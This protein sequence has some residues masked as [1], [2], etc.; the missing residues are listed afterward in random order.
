MTR[1]WIREC[2][3]LIGSSS[4]AI[5]VSQLRIRFEVRMWDVQHPGQ[6]DVIVTNLSKETSQKIQKEYDKVLLQVGWRDGQ[7]ATLFEGETV[8]KRRGRETPT[9]VYDALLVREAQTAYSFATISKTLASGH[10][11][12]DQIDACLEAL[13]PYGI[14]AGYIPDLP[15]TKMPRGRV[16]FGM[17]RQQLRT[18]CASTGTSWHIEGNKLVVLENGKPRPGE[19]IV[20]NSR[21]GLIG[22]P[23]QTFGGIEARCLLNPDIKWGSLVKIDQASIQQA[24]LQLNEP[25]DIALQQSTLP[26]TDADGFYRVAEVRHTGDTRG[27]D[28]YTDIVCLSASNLASGNPVIP[29]SINDRGIAPVVDKKN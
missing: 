21:T 25:D 28:W 5:D 3:L 15:A 16:L 20:L 17:V 1:Q 7:M 14:T 11:F 24:K 27:T 22:M 2:R 8:Q 26:P 9:E 29:Q 19:A 4:E 23:T 18:I 12:R 13:K 6:A 10:T